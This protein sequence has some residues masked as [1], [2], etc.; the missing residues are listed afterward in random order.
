MGARVKRIR[1][2]RYFADNE[3]ERNIRKIDRERRDYHRYYTGQDWENMENYDLILNSA[4]L[5]TDGC[6]QCIIEYLKIRGLL[7]K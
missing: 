5:G 1:E 6:V 4:K 3:V 7:A 2:K